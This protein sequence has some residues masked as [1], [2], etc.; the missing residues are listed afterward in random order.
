MN[1]P[2]TSASGVT[3]AVSRLSRVPARRSS[4]Q[5]R[6][7]SAATRKMSSSGSHRKRG[8]TSAMLRAKKVSPQKKAK[9]TAARNAPRKR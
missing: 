8:R 7:V 2:S 5:A 1:L 6:M 3:G 4:D 9:S